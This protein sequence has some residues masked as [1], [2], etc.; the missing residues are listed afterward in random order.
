MTPIEK[1]KWLAE[2]YG[3]IAEGKTVQQL[4]SGKW[5]DN[6]TNDLVGPDMSSNPDFWRIKPEPRRMWEAE[7]G[8]I[9]ESQKEAAEWRKQGLTVTEWVEV[10]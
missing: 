3:A 9:T 10:V 6:A 8:L 5:R 1:A 7:S 2:F 4:F